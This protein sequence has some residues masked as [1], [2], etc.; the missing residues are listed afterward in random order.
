MSSR[1]CFTGPI[2]FLYFNKCLLDY[3]LG[4]WQSVTPHEDDQTVENFRY[5]LKKWFSA[6]LPNNTF[7]IQKVWM[8]NTMKKSFIMR[9]KD[10][11]DMLKT[12]NWFLMQMLYDEDKDMIFTNMNLKAL[13]LKSMPSTWQISYLLKGNTSLNIFW[14]MLAYLLQFQSITDAHT[15]TRSNS[16]SANWD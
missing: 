11:G 10:R 7:L 1:I 8:T 14:Q 13:L 3:S 15:V 6:L 9:V 16:A 5:V 4:E 2:M 12:L